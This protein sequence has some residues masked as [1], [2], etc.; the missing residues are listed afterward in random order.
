[1]KILVINASPRKKGNTAALLEKIVKSYP[2]H[3][4][5]KV[6]QLIDMQMAQCRGCLGCRPDKECVLARDDAHVLGRELKEADLVIIGSPCYWGNIPG[7]LKT[8]FDRNVTTFESIGEGYIKPA[9][10]G[11]RAVIAVTSGAPFPFNLLPTQSTGTVR[12]LKLALRAGG[13]KIEK[14]VN[15][16]GAPRR[17]AENE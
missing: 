16:A 8:F 4:E 10:K 15:V 17:G 7:T 9:L 1:M 6:R 3:S 12:A 2:G 14:I 11:K 13:M 5:V